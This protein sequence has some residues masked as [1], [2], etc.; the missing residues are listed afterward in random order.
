[1]VHNDFVTEAWTKDPL[2][3]LFNRIRAFPRDTAKACT[4]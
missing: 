4:P 3:L 1:V 2:K